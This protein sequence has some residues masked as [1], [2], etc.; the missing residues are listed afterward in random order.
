MPVYSFRNKDTGEEFSEM[1]SIA[2]KEKFLE[3]NPQIEQILTHFPAMIDSF[4]LGIRKPDPEFRERLREIQK[5][6][7]YGRVE[8]YRD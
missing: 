2:E 6:H 8:D 4:Q 3:E 1:M 7:P 5:A